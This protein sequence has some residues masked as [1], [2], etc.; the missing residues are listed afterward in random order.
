M[1]RLLR[2]L[3]RLTHPPLILEIG[4]SIGYSTTCMAQVVSEW[5]GTVTTIEFDERVS[6]QARADAG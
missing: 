3:V 4:T 5:G 2:L 1:A 6:K